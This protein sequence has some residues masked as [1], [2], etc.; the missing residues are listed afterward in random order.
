MQDDLRNNFYFNKFFIK[1]IITDKGN[2]GQPACPGEWK[3]CK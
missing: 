1:D 2:G 3:K